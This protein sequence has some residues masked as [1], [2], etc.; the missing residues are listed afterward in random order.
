MRRKAR[1]RQ[2]YRDYDTALIEPS[3][4]IAVGRPLSTPGSKYA[5]YKGKYVRPPHT[6][7]G[8]KQRKLCAQK[9]PARRGIRNHRRAHQ[10]CIHEN[11]STATAIDSSES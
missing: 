2:R 4:A 11:L 9:R 1:N 7:I 10:P 8:V 3:I 6:S 5:D